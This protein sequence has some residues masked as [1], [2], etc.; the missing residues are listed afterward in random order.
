M[1]SPSIRAAAIL[2]V[3]AI[4]A[5]ASTGGGDSDDLLECNK[6][7]IECDNPD[8]VADSVGK[9][10]YQSPEDY[11]DDTVLDDED[12]CPFAF[13]DAQRDADGDSTGDECDNCPNH[14]N[15]DQ[16]DA[17]GDGIG[18]ACDNDADGDRILNGND[19]CPSYFNKDQSDMDEDGLGDACDDDIDGDEVENLLDI[20]PFGAD[21]D[22]D[23]CNGDSD[24]DGVLDFDL[25]GSEPAPGDN[26]PTVDNPDQEDLDQDG[27]GDACDPDLDGD[28]IFNSADNCRNDHNP[29][30]ED[31][32]R[33]GTGSACDTSF[34]YTVFGDANNC[35]D[36]DAPFE[37][38][39]PNN[40]DADIGNEIR[41][42]LFA[43]RQN[44]ALR[45]RWDV[46]GG[47]PEGTRRIENASGTVSLSTP[48][49]YRYSKDL[50][51][52]FTPNYA[53]TYY[54]RV[55]AEQVFEDDITG[56]VG[57]IAEAYPVIEASGGS[58]TE[59][60]D[61]SCSSVGK[62]GNVPG[63]SLVLALIAIVF[64]AAG[65]ARL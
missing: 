35:L 41:L 48:F 49:E 36:P 29:D 8:T 64:C 58:I 38:Y 1:I 52:T 30:Q 46:I 4:A 62:R 31:L 39:S 6:D 3:L 5:S 14:E 9:E 37:I 56:D 13:N 18:D 42:R 15:S 12:N 65:R 20:C 19:N 53:G 34:C 11:D 21:P 54:L 22:A 25:S 23:E 33:D 26:C 28:G 45:Y 7:D 59:G 16:Y 55:A 47:P 2:C 17:D 40:L 24:G 27:L 51:P 32:D 61:C 57:L 63:A 50:E 44:S 43:N 60:G 10:G